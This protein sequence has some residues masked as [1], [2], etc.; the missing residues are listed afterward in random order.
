MG[1]GNFVRIS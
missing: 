1:A